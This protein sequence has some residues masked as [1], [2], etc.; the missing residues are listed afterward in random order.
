VDYSYIPDEKK[1]DD[2]SDYAD[3]YKLL[4]EYG[5]CSEYCLQIDDYEQAAMWHSHYSR[6]I[7]SILTNKKYQR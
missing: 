3:N 2:L 6:Q 7:G 1:E 4:F 5:I